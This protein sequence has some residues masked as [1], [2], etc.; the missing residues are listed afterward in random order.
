[1]SAATRVLV[2]GL[3]SACFL[4]GCGDAGLVPS[5]QSLDQVVGS[6][7]D[8]G[9]TATIAGAV[10]AEQGSD[11]GPEATVAAY[12]EACRAGD[13]SAVNRLLTSI[14]RQKTQEMDIA[15]APPGS[16][17]AQF[18]VLAHEFLDPEQ[19]TSH[20]ASRWTDVGANGTQES[21]DI[22]WVAKR[23]E[24]GW[25]IAGARRSSQADSGR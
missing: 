11:S 13:L 15:V 8:S 3:I 16:E 12:L 21:L 6:P 17:T 25:R 23:E 19:L 22:I 10:P 1:M 2:V 4:T 18:E 7:E 9:Q 14:A 24:N 5:G 20:V